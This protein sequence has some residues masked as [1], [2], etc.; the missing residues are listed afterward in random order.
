[1]NFIIIIS[2][3]ICIILV[4]SENPTVDITKVKG[5]DK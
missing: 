5:E 1:M 4:L 3:I 2:A